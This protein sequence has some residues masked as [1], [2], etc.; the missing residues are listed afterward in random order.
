MD[1]LVDKDILLNIELKNGPVFYPGIEKIVVDMIKKYNITEKVII[2]SFNHYCLREIKALAP[3]IKIGLLYSAGLY[4]PA[5]YAKMVGADAIHPYYLSVH[6]DSIKNCK[7]NGILINVWTI[8]NPDHIKLAIFAGADGII[9]N[10]PDVAL[11]ILHSSL[12][13]VCVK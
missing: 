6:P 9:T 3:D 11:K 8:N 1:L 12:L 7:E 4:N 13:A 10:Y 2:S 5:E